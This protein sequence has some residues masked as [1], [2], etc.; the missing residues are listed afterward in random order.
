M[1]GDNPYIL[2]LPPREKRN[3]CLICN[4]KVPKRFVKYC[5]KKCRDKAIRIRWQPYYSLLQQRRYDRKAVKKPGRIQCLICGR[6]Y[7]QVGS[8]IAWRHEMTCREYRE[9]F[10]LERK[11]GILPPD[12]KEL[13]ARWVFENGTIKNL[14]AGKKFWFKKGDPRIGKYRRSHITMARLKNQFKQYHYEH[15]KNKTLQNV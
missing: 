12:L 15:Q 10:D 1:R 3:R 2:P 6:W 4:G 13:K 11:R 14:Q 9:F 7:R 8:H 5:S